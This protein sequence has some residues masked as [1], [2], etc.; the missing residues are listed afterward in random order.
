MRDHEFELYWDSRGAIAERAEQLFFFGWPP[1]AVSR[2][3]GAS[4]EAV[5]WLY[6][7][8]QVAEDEAVTMYCG[9]LSEQFL[10]G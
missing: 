4:L 5:R 10:A 7:G 2:E 6:K 9:Y 3:T 1:D 8:F